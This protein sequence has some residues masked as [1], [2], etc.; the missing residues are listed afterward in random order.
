[1]SAI[2]W[3]CWN[4]VDGVPA[5][6]CA[7]EAADLLAT[8]HSGLRGTDATS[9]HAVFDYLTDDSVD[10]AAAPAIRPV[11]HRIVDDVRD[12][13]D[14]TWGTCYGDGPEAIRTGDGQIAHIDWGGVLHAPLLWDVADWMDGYTDPDQ[15]RF[16]DACRR[17]IAEI[18]ADE[19]AHLDK[20]RRL[21]DAR[22]L[23]FAAYRVLRADHY[24]T[25]AERDLERFR[26]YAA[27]L[28]IQLR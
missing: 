25:T 14:L 16:V 1:M 10:F 8:V 11:L 27:R 22:T 23:R 17:G 12:C 18:G 15:Q 5:Q 26:W 7:T 28:G 19:F 21:R 13:P 3:P 4:T 9:T 6:L 20:L 24:R 2:R